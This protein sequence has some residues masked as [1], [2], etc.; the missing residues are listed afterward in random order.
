MTTTTITGDTWDVYFNDRRYRNLLGDFED[1][2][3]ET[4]SLIR[5][6]Y[7]MDV[8]KNKMDNKAL[9]LQSKFKELGQILL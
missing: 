6:G 8:I 5:Q 1:L 2:I 7:K 4:K 3:T 9:S